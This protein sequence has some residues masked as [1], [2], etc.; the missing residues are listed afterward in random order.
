MRDAVLLRNARIVLPDRTTEPTS[1]LIEDGRVGRVFNSSETAPA[2]SV[3][4][5]DLAGLT[6]FPGFID[7]HIHG[8]TGVDAM[9]ASTDD[10]L[11][12]ASFLSRNG[13]TAWLPTLVPAPPDQ[14]Q[15]AITAVESAIVQQRVFASSALDADKMSAL[16]AVG[17]RVLGVHYEGPFVNNE[18]CGALHREY[19]R[20]FKQNSDV[21]S[22]PTLPHSEAI[23]MM[24]LAPEIEGGI[25]LINELDKRDWIVSIGHT[26]ATVDVLDQAL[27]AVARPRT[28]FLYA[29]K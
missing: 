7:I 19:F 11:K 6:L 1:V 15:R 16:T 3:T 20:T 28:D 2:S 23:H 21:D 12:L 25:A 24:T 22:L 5:I 4:G 13:V 26:R 27:E 17:A 8:A 18:Q 14:Y 29:M 9:D 10:L